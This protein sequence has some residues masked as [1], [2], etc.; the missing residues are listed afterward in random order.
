LKF[1]LA[2]ITLNCS[3]TE[4]KISRGFARNRHSNQVERLEATFMDELFNICDLLMIVAA[5]KYTVF[6]N[7]KTKIRASPN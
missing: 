6:N 7:P 2:T 1:G 4:L 3:E 5:M